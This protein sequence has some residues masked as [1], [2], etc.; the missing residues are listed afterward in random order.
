M[1]S[2]FLTIEPSLELEFRL[3][4]E[5]G[6]KKHAVALTIPDAKTGSPLSEG[7]LFVLVGVTLLEEARGAVFHR[8][9]RDTKRSQLRVGQ[10]P[11]GQESTT[12]M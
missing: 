2:C 8:H 5:K 7:D 11:G 3:Q 6:Q 10:G 1:R 9:Q 12:Q 4:V